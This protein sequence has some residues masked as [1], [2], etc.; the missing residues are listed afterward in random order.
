M[1]QENNDHGFPDNPYNKHAW[2]LG[3]PEI[4]E[5][6]WIGAF[7]LIDSMHDKLTIGRGVDVSSGAQILTHSTA[8]RC[9]SERKYPKI[10][11]APTVVGDHCFIGTN[12]VILMGAI[13]GHHSVIGAGAVVT[14]GMEIPPYSL[15]LGVPAKI[16]G[17]SKYFLK[18]LPE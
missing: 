4:G 16:K 13:I 9:I 11:H 18:G 10:D 2:V 7:C 17:S 1:A 15:V 12:A 14:Q 5:G 3:N 8:R 6:T